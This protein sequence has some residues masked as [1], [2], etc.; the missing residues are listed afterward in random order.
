MNR[1]RV[2]YDSN[3]DHNHISLSTNKRSKRAGKDTFSRVLNASCFVR[4][5]G[6]YA[7]DT[8]CLLG[9]LSLCPSY[10]HPPPPEKIHHVRHAG[11]VCDMEM[12]GESERVPPSRSSPTK[13]AP[14]RTR[15]D[16]GERPEGRQSDVQRA[17]IQYGLAYTVAYG[18]STCSVNFLCPA[19]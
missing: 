17:A 11:S 8:P 9:V 12:L 2:Y 15:V 14:L 7:V 16:C 13:S 5:S 3:T 19:T 1:I 6:I 4:I 18:C 10:P